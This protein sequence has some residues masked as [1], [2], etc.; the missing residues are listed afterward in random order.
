MKKVRV[1]WNEF[2][3]IKRKRFTDDYVMLREIGKGTFGFVYKVILKNSNI[4]RAAKKIEKK[5]LG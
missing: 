5:N 2:I 4:Y 1:K 3:K